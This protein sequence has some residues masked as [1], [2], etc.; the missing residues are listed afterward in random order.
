MYESLDL[1]LLYNFYIINFL[2]YENIR[3]Y[4]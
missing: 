2:L 1:D 4:T 3:C